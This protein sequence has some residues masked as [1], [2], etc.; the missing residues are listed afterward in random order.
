MAFPAEV[1]ELDK[2][3]DNP[4]LLVHS[5]PGVGKTTWATSD[6]KVLVIN[7]ENKGVISARHSK[8]RG[9][10]IRQWKVREWN[11][12]VKCYEWL[13]SLGTKIPFKW[14]VIDTLS[15]LQDRQLMRHILNEVHAK[16]STRDLYIPDK[17]E[18]LRNQVMLVEYVKLFNDLP[19]GV[20]ILAHTMELT[21]KG[22]QYLLPQVQGGIDKGG[23]VAQQVLSMMTSFGYMY[24][25]QKT[26][27]KGQKLIDGV[28]RAPLLERVIQWDSYGQSMGKDRTGVLGFQTVDVTLKEIRL[29]MEA[30]DK[31]IEEENTEKEKV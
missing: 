15:T 3:D 12:F 18:Y 2:I 14:V 4:N 30:A 25:Q 28:T 8:I 21:I 31:A 16:K 23:K 24:E 27:E 1:V 13:Y 29:R 7:C 6:D 22:E 11:D 26:N 9:N 20:I 10:H 19:V 17:P 5:F